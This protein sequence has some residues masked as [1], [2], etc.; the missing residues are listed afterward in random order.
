MNRE[1]AIRAGRRPRAAGSARRSNTTTSSSMR[2]PPR[3]SFRKSSSRPLT[4][5]SPSSRLWR[6][7]AWDMSQGPSARSFS[8]ISGDTYGRRNVLLICLVLMG[9]STT[10]V[11]LLPTYQQ[12]GVWAP[13][14]LVASAPHP[15]FC[16]RGR[17]IGRELHDSRARAVR[18]ARLFCELHPARRAGGTNPGGRLLSA[19]ELRASERGFHRPGGGACRSCSAFS[20]WSPAIS[21]GA[22]SRRRP[23]SPKRE[24][25]ARCRR[26]R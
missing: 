22:R 4:R 26:P 16:G 6:L 2:P 15:G 23:R 12:V 3:W 21:F 10:A 17:D 20:S 18:A 14:L 7:T 8:A 24:G 11:G 5:P 13:V 9:L 19:F 25:R 1:R